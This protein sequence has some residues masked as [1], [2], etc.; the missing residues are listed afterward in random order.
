M[1]SVVGEV[2]LLNKNSIVDSIQQIKLDVRK[3]ND[4][5]LEISDSL[6]AFKTS[7]NIEVKK[8][9]DV[10]KYNSIVDTL[11]ND[12]QVLMNRTGTGNIRYKD[13]ATSAENLY[14]GLPTHSLRP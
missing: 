10:I 2:S 9:G 11:V 14:N 3:L 4:S 6:D 1:T 8:I 7:V 5:G 13:L 12:V